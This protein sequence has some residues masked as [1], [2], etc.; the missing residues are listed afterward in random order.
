M[1]VVFVIYIK[2]AIKRIA[3]AELSHT[4]K[5]WEDRT[6]GHFMPIS[7]VYVSRNVHSARATSMYC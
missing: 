5:R 3:G 4:K 1:Y 2:I 7:C 6:M